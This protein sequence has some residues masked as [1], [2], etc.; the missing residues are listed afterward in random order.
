MM[1]LMKSEI[2][3][4]IKEKTNGTKKKLLYV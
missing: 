4:N 2:K 1:G 3:E